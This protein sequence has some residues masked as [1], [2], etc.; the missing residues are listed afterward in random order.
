M[1]AGV[2]ELNVTDEAARWFGE[3]L[4]GNRRRTEFLAWLEES[5]RHVE[6]FLHV[7]ADAQDI[8][9]LS[10]TQQARIDELSAELGTNGDEGSNVVP[11]SSR[12]AVLKHTN[13]H[14][15]RARSRHGLKYWVLAGIAAAAV[16]VV[17]ALPWL[18]DLERSQ[19]Y[20]TR[21]GEQRAVQLADGSTI[22]MN[23]DSEIV[24]HLTDGARRVKLVR[25]EAL[26]SVEHDAR[27][28]FLVESGNAVIQAIGTRFDVYR[29]AR[30]IRVAV[31]EGLVQVSEAGSDAPIPE[32]HSES[33]RSLPTQTGAAV[34]L[35]AAG[36]GTELSNRGELSKPVAVDTKKTE[37]WR[38]R[39]LVFEN[40]S[41]ADIASDFNRYNAHIKIFVLDDG[42]RDQQ[43]SGTFDADDP[44]A[45]TQALALD[46]T[47]QV[48]RARN[49]IVIRSRKLGGP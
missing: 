30:G 21:L 1:N 14:V 34:Q 26:F 4:E 2:D 46:P 19:T 9:Q 47:L 11:L 35:L 33:K 20:L 15:R 16:L 41:L 3:L 6:E 31:L 27:R 8:A 13:D 45:I 22:Q 24:V 18:L 17:I 7:M 37:A 10:V 23:T 43:F 32:H 28:P 44:E 29:R 25:G 42:A 40:D 48:E 36:Q 38:Q 5:P 12:Q 39:R 49:D